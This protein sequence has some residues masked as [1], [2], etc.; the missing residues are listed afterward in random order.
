MTNGN[1]LVI[2]TLIV[3]LFF[4]LFIV[5]TVKYEECNMENIELTKTIDSLN[6]ELFKYKLERSAGIILYNNYMNKSHLNIEE[7]R[8]LDSVMVMLTDS[9]DVERMVRNYNL[10]GTIWEK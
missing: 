8:V 4:T 7:S 9:S 2:S 10:Y 3:L 1:L 6:N 5:S